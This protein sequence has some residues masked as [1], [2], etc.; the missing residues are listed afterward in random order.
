[1]VE[2]STDLGVWN[3]TGVYVPY[4]QIRRRHKLDSLFDSPH[5]KSSMTANPIEYNSD[6]CSE[7]SQ[8]ALHGE[9]ETT[10]RFSTAVNGI[11]CTAHAVSTHAGF[12]SAVSQA[13]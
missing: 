5:P 3:K 6:I 7:D 12:K 13:G 4:P 10:I 2:A 1:M 8:Y 9:N 11:P